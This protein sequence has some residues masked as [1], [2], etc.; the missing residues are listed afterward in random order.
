VKRT[1]FAVCAVLSFAACVQDP[2]GLCA[3]DGDCMSGQHCSNGICLS[4]QRTFGV[5]QSCYADRDCVAWADCTEGECVL[6]P[7]L[8]TATPDC[9]GWQACNAVHACESVPNGCEDDASCASWQ[10]CSSWRCATRPGFCGSDANCSAWEDCRADHLCA[11]AAGFCAAD[12]ECASWQVCDLVS[13][14]C[15]TGAGRCAADADCA[16][17]EACGTDHVCALAPGRCDA[18]SDCNEW[19]VCGT[20]HVCA[21]APDRCSLD[22]DCAEW[23]ACGAEHACVTD[24]GFCA[25]DAGCASWERCDAVAHTCGTAPGRCVGGADCQAWEV[26]G[27]DHVCATAPNGCADAGGC[28]SWQACLEYRCATGPGHCADGSE[29]ASWK[30]CDSTHVC[31]LQPGSCDANADCLAWQYCS[32]AHACTD[33]GAACG[34]DADCEAWQACS[35][36]HCVN[37][38]DRCAA[39]QQCEPSWQ[40]CNETENAC[41][42][43]PDRCATSIECAGWE[44]CSAEHLCVVEPCATATDCSGGDACVDGFCAA[45][46]VFDPDDVVIFGTAAEAVAGRAAVAPL[47]APRRVQV[48]FP[49]DVYAYYSYV[50]PEGR[51]MYR[52]G[53]GGSTIRTFTA[54]H[55]RWD[56]SAN[57]PRWEYPLDPG[58]NDPVTPSPACPADTDRYRWVMQAGTGEV[59]YQCAGTSGSDVY[60]DPTGA[61]R[62]SG[63]WLHAWNANGRM[64]GSQSYS[65]YVLDPDTDTRIAVTNGPA[66]PVDVAFARAW[67]D[68]FRFLRVHDDG[69]TRVAERW[70]VDAAGVA[71]MDGV[72]PARP[73][74]DWQHVLDGAGALYSQAPIDWYDVVFRCTLSDPECA[75]VYEERDLPR[76]DYEV[77]PPRVSVRFHGSVLIT[78]P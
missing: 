4:D 77:T 11:T 52:N 41:V 38:A 3:A 72:F 15:A 5:G 56:A 49:W 14:S 12:E 64:L 70:S 60:Y 42:A 67:S 39:D 76:N 26:C 61:L 36:G 21:T 69:G 19:Q 7:G 32:E 27:V 53:V 43:A 55:W 51:I 9:E 2:G 1:L 10:V 31:A 44:S 34:V 74:L 71:T 20:S 75:I 73:I 68:G 28:A 46:V 54:D 47:L 66:W 59:L 33:V 57:P 29:C 30:T 37:Q 16:E 58:A 8:C 78:G 63:Y 13:H 45:P 48:G 62:V 65:L 40:T 35:G 50:T 24:V 23:Q 22:E 25:D 6:T 18:Q 17:W